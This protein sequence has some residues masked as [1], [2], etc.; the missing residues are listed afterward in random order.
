MSKTFG[1]FRIGDSLAGTDNIVGFK[2][3]NIVGGERRWT[4]QQ[5]LDYMKSQLLNIPYLE[6]AWTCPASQGPQTLVKST[7]TTLWIDTLIANS[8]NLPGT[9]VAGYTITLP[10]GTYSFEIY[11]PI[12][13][14]RSNDNANANINPNFIFGLKNTTTQSI[15]S[16]KNSAP[17]SDSNSESTMDNTITGRF[18]I[19]YS[20][21]FIVE[22][23]CTNRAYIGSMIGFS[24]AAGTDQRTTIKFWKL[25]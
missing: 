18:T 5:L 19:T 20:C 10:A 2:D 24:G 3:I 22:G 4:A 21:N 17:A 8:H 15:V 1:E 16:R 14:D 9:G 7:I 11:V 13:L 23:V 6:Y 12:L 25:A